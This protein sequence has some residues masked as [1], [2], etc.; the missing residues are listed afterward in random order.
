MLFVRKALAI[1][2]PERPD[3]SLSVTV[4]R[5]SLGVPNGDSRATLAHQ[6][7]RLAN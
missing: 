3:V 7:D 5:D 6:T 1:N 2:G 4:F